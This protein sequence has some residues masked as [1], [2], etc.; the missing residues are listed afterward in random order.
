MTGSGVARW[1]AAG[2]VFLGGTVGVGL[3]FALSNAGPPDSGGWPWG[4][5]A[6]NLVGAFLLGL[7]VAGLASAGPD[8]GWRRQLRL[9]VGTGVLGGFT[10][11]STFAVEVVDLAGGGHW[12]LS[13]GY[14]LGSVVLGLLAAWAG[15]WLG[16][17]IGRGR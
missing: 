10:T 17:R 14:A 1:Q 3:R 6:I 9:G 2:V 4:I 16:H 5:F 12:G 15:L 11:Y 7:L 13:L 8:R